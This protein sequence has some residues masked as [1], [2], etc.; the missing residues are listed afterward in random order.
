[1]LA[2]TYLFNYIVNSLSFILF[3]F[4]SCSLNMTMYLETLKNVYYAFKLAILYKS[5]EHKD[6]SD[7]GQVLLFH[8]L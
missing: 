6:F 1:M 3:V 7:K 4:I 2:N 8:L 5:L